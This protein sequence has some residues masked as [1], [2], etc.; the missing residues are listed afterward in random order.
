[1]AVVDATCAYTAAVGD[2]QLQLLL[3]LLALEGVPNP[4]WDPG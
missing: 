1:V 4:E 2:I 3:D